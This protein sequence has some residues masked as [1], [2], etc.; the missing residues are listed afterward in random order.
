MAKETPYFE[1]F[2]SFTLDTA[3]ANLITAN[4]RDEVDWV[5]LTSCN[6]GESYLVLCTPIDR[7]PTLAEILDELKQAGFIDIWVKNNGG[8]IVT[9]RR[10]SF[11]KPEVVTLEQKL[12]LEERAGKPLN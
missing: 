4:L 5:N 10:A 2:T 12:A 7:V 6:T 11:P 1:H 9:Y 8:A 3:G